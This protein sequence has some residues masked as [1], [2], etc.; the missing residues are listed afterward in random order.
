MTIATG[1][2]AMIAP[3]AWSAG[4]G[5]LTSPAISQIKSPAVINR[6]ISLAGRR[7]HA[8]VPDATNTQAATTNSTTA[9][10]GGAGTPE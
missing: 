8:T 4:T 7:S 6:P 9:H 1:N 2:I 5:V 10:G 3:A